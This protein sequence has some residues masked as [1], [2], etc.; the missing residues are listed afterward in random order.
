MIPILYSS[1]TNN[2]ENAGLGFLADC[3]SCE[4][5]EERNGAFECVI[6]YPVAGNLFEQV[7][8]GGI[9]KCKP[10]ETSNLQL[11]KIYQI[12]KPINGIITIYCEHISYAL[13]GIPCV[14]IVAQSMS[15]NA[16]MSQVLNQ[17][18][19]QNNF[20]FWCN[21]S[22]QGKINRPEPCSIRSVLGGSDGSILDV[23][24][25]EYEFD[26]F[27][28]KLHK[29]R[30]NDNGVTIEYGK[31]LTDIKQETNI[32]EC[33]T[34]IFPYAKQED[35]ITMLDGYII[36]LEN[37]EFFGH[38]RVLPIDLSDQF[39]NNGEETTEI[40]QEM[41]QKAAENYIKSHD[42][43]KPKISITVSFAPLWQSAEFAEFAGLERVS[44]CDTVKVKF[45]RLGI[46]CKSKVIKTVYDCLG[47][48]YISVDL[49]DAKSDFASTII[50]S[51]NKTDSKLK[52]L[53]EVIQTGLSDGA[54][55][56]EDAI[57]NATNLITG[58]SGGYVVF[59]PAEKPQEILIMDTPDVNTAVR[60]WRWNLSG[61][62]YSSTGVNG[63]F[64]LAMTMDGHIV[65]DYI[66]VGTLDGTLLRADS[67]QANAISQGFKTE[68]N[69]KITGVKTTV[70][71]EFQVADEQLKSS[72]SKT[73]EDTQAEIAES[74]STLIQQT[75]STI[76]FEVDKKYSTKTETEEMKSTIE[77]K[78]D[79]I[80]LSVTGRLDGLDGEIDSAV[81]RI[82]MAV[83]KDENG[84]MIGT[85]DIGAN[86]ISIKSD[87]FEL[88]KSGDIIAKNA[89]LYGT[90][91]SKPDG[92]DE[93]GRYAK[94]DLGGLVFYNDNKPIATYHCYG[95]GSYRTGISCEPDGT[96]ITF[97]KN[98]GNNV[99]TPVVDI[100]FE[101]NLTTFDTD[102]DMNGHML[103][104]LG[105]GLT[106][107]LQM[108]QPI[109]IRSDGTIDSYSNVE[110][111]FK[112]GIL[113]NGSWS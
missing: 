82:N 43:G 13:N 86:Q 66:A 97:D 105:G 109:S 69:D 85:L 111:E 89:V 9:V 92:T 50:K 31:N 46:E 71:Q 103:K 39:N 95:D 5:T 75:Y 113:V 14:G 26:N 107:T 61:L 83:I 78:Y 72:I 1:D 2:F 40:T 98:D 42:L 21:I 96:G 22:T 93:Y 34:H 19:I 84:K 23:F 7:K 52:D 79:A 80:N 24:G 63:P 90:I 55:A 45:A 70:T 12:D 104:N 64:G 67:V 112:N 25:G 65:A 27:T 4:V 16:I 77:Q 28:I 62:G 74:T 102:I 32:A 56:L 59:R 57:A 37:A 18:P 11:F 54:K 101:N 30:G 53:T 20:E 3:I 88:T 38:T 99:Y 29:N 49:G 44:L 35:K 100:D 58:N 10:N 48:K 60:V 47:E 76:T 87:N 68:I 94:L 51:E 15:A 17:T 73:I 110:L 8:E 33:Y 106:G 108:I 81:S 91:Y 6:T 41:L 36:E